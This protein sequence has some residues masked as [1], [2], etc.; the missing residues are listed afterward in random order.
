VRI[1]TVVDTGDDADVVERVVSH[2]LV[3]SDVVLTRSAAATDDTRAI[4]AGLLRRGTALVVFDAERWPGVDD[5]D[6]GDFWRNLRRH[7]DP[8]LV[9][10]L[11]RRE[12][13]PF[14][15]RADLER[16]AAERMMPGRILR[17]DQLEAIDAPRPHGGSG[18][19]PQ[20]TSP[21]APQSAEA[22]LAPGIWSAAAHA[23]D[24]YVDVPP[25]QY[26]AERYAPE[27]VLDIGCG[28]GAYLA[29]FQEQGT[30][31]VRGI[32]GFS[33]TDAVL[34]P[35]AYSQHDLRSPLDLGRT[36]DV[37]LCVEV[38]EHLEAE[39]ETT[40][41]D[42]IRRHARTRI[43]FSAAQPGQPGRHHV[44]CRPIGHWLTRWR[45]V[46]WEPDIPDTVA[47]RS[48]ATYIWFRRNLLILR[49]S[50][51]CSP[52]WLSDTDLIGREAGAMRWYGQRPAVH[53]RP[54][55]EPLAPLDRTASRGG[56]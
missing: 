9:I 51:L 41:L 36:F 30:A 27:S 47:A 16:G 43:M 56:G 4:L 5:A 17:R 44:N 32:D 8:D 18:P 23:Q 20:A 28:L 29:L 42:T 14:T 46:G 55:E 2:A 37:V 45:L 24:L 21:P 1:V 50:H 13:A 40:L 3:F 22:R 35:R 39:H 15:S 26:A 6:D 52:G 7:F 10:R 11:G 38:I 49:P 34:C 54:F 33:D 48:L 25:F 12:F 53:L 31:T 19:V